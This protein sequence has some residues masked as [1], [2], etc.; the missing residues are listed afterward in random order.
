MDSNFLLARFEIKTWMLV[1][2]L[3]IAKIVKRVPHRFFVLRVAEVY[4]FVVL[5]FLWLRRNTF[6]TLWGVPFCDAT[7]EGT[8]ILLLQNMFIFPLNGFCIH[9]QVG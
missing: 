9:I 8:S 2:Q 5:L 1:N 7:V 3:S 4:W 6:V